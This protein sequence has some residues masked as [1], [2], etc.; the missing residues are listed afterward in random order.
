MQRV[1][2]WVRKPAVS[3]MLFSV[4]I[5]AI[6]VGTGDLRND[7]AVYGWIA[8]RMVVT[9][10]Y[11][12]LY[13]DWGDT[14]YFNKPPLLF[15]LGAL[16]FHVFGVTTLAAK[17]VSTAFGVACVAMTYRLARFRFSPAVSATAGMVLTSAMFFVR[18]ATGYRPD[19]GVT[20][21]FLLSLLAGLGMLGE[22][23]ARSPWR[24]QWG[25]WL[26]MGVAMGLGFMHKGPVAVT[27]PVVVLLTAAW[28]RQWRVLFSARWLVSF[29]IALVIILPWHVQQSLHYG[30]RFWSVYFGRE[31]A[32]RFT[33]DTFRSEPIWNYAR[34]LVMF[35]W[36][37]LPFMVLGLIAAWRSRR[38][39]EPGVFAPPRETAMALLVVWLV[40]YGIAIHLIVRKYG[41]YMIPWV[42][43]LSMMSAVGLFLS[44]LRRVWY[45]HVMPNIGW[46][47]LVLSAVLLL[48]GVRSG[49]VMMPELHAVADQINQTQRP[50]AVDRPVVY[51]YEH[52]ANDMD[53]RCA[54]MFYTEAKCVPL[55]GE[56]AFAS[57]PPGQFV[58]VP[59]KHRPLAEKEMP[60]HEL[61]ASGK[62]YGI[63][64]VRGVNGE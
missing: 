55:K 10:D 48:S 36:P 57:V 64:R 51:L 41:R 44:P 25:P 24:Q 52:K 13:Y 43:V 62:R 19:T 23:R 26:L 1:I 20:F 6:A 8:K 60:R 9:G 32:S 7:S 40:I 4:A 39:R 34:T 2:Q 63:Y 15:W 59:E 27:G 21:F 3:M 46:G 58:V 35:Y 49:M 12:N 47:G 33:G 30:D 18:N 31:T 45:R 38:A 16:S 53:T 17:L 5:F 61:I 29:A 50:G 14:P 37:W 56:A 22:W 28:L 42:P 11:F 54:I